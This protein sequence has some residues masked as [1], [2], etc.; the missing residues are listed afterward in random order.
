MFAYVDLLVSL[1]SARH[2]LVLRD[3]TKA[4]LQLTIQSRGEQAQPVTL[5]F[6]TTQFAKVDKATVPLKGSLCVP[7]AVLDDCAETTR[8]AVRLVDSCNLLLDAASMSMPSFRRL[9]QTLQ[10]WTMDHATLALQITRAPRTRTVPKPLS[11]SDAAPGA[12]VADRAAA[13]HLLPNAVLRVMVHELAGFRASSP[14]ASLVFRQVGVD[15]EQRAR[16]GVV[17]KATLPQ[18]SRQFVFLLSTDAPPPSRKLPIA[19]GTLKIEI[20]KQGVIKDEPYGRADILLEQAAAAALQS[21][22]CSVTQWHKLNTGRGSVLVQIV[23]PAQSL[24]K[25]ADEPA[26]VAPAP[27]PA[28]SAPAND[29]EDTDS[30][31]SVPDV[32]DVDAFELTPPPFIPTLSEL[33]E[34]ARSFYEA[35]GVTFDAAAVAEFDRKSQQLKDEDARRRAELRRVQRR[36]SAS[37]AALRM[38]DDNTTDDDDDDGDDDAAQKKRLLAVPVV[39]ARAAAPVAV[40][41]A[42]DDEPPTSLLS[43]SITLQVPSFPARFSFRRSAS[44]ENLNARWRQCAVCGEESDDVDGLFTQDFCPH[45]VCVECVLSAVVRAADCDRVACPV[46]KCAGSTSN[47]VLRQ[48]LPTDEFERRLDIELQATL[49]AV[50]ADPTRRLVRC[51]APECGFVCEAS[52]DAMA[53]GQDDDNDDADDNDDDAE[54]PTPSLAAIERFRQRRR[55]RCR[56]CF[57][58]FCE[59]CRRTPFHDGHTCASL[60][61]F[62]AAPKC[63]FCGERAV[64]GQTVCDG[65]ECAAKQR[66]A[67]THV[68]ACGHACHGLRFE[69]THVP[70]LEADCAA[71]EAARTAAKVTQTGDDFCNI[72]WVD[73]LAGAPSLQLKCGHVFHLGCIQRRLQERWGNARIS[74][75]FAGCPLCHAPMEHTALAR[76]TRSV[77]KLRE[78]IERMAVQRLAHEGLEKDAAIVRGRFK[79]DAVGFAMNRY[80]YYECHKC[81]LP[82]FGGQAQCAGG[83]GENEEGQFDE[84]LLICSSCASGGQE[85][86]AETNCRIHGKDFIEFKCKFCCSIA[87]WFCWGTTHLCEQC[88]QTQ[89]GTYAGAKMTRRP[90]A[91]FPQHFRFEVAMGND[92]KQ[93]VRLDKCPLGLKSH[94]PNGTADMS[95]GCTICKQMKEF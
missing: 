92:A 71:G 67:C 3:H 89:A 18:I 85:Q 64:V 73:P 14:V 27:A 84:K 20:A 10:I 77:V 2:Q 49:K 45:H 54:S 38:D 78:Q 69:A 53:G 28:P 19:P 21:P 25:P 61:A 41:A 6:A 91:D 40:V 1:E 60:A 63:R 12:G 55:F 56:K 66:I 72:C 68:H 70:C 52:D 57:I 46:P 86:T 58:D 4:Q 95:L 62:E 37:G 32:A 93:W 50:S 74:F 35:G 81:K 48:I 13:S 15:G 76:A 36:L 30:M 82:Y 8:V 59:V 42:V 80:A 9:I 51:P 31:Q 5:F 88:H 22:D 90:I 65:D 29:A 79:G 17:D 83:P 23:F 75:A 26:A 87:T 44:G 11:A 7:F 24:V 33:S 47:R 39:P 34:F 43:S 16:S 94:P